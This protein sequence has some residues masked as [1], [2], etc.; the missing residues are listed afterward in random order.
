MTLFDLIMIKLPKTIISIAFGM[1]VSE[2]ALSD[3]KSVLK[4]TVFGVSSTL[5]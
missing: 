2:N 3:L 1:S 5:G 4:Q